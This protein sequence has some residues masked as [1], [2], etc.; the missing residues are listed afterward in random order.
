[1]HASEREPRRVL[2]AAAD[3]AWAGAQAQMLELAA[4]LDPAEFAPVLLTTGT[5]ELVERARAAG[6]PTHL[7]PFGIVRRQFPFVDYYA[8]GPLR[9]HALLSRERIALVH[10]HDPNSIVSLARAAGRRRVPIV[11]HIHDLDQRWVTKRTVAALHTARSAFATTSD[12]AA[13]YAIGCGAD[14]ERVRRIYNGVHLAAF[15]AGTRPRVRAGLH[16]RDDEVAV[17]LLGRMVERKGQADLVRAVADARVAALP[18]RVF[19]IGGTATRDAAY[20]Q[21]LRALATE[22]GVASRVTFLGEREDATLLLGGMDLSVVP[23]RREA[24]GRVVVEGMHAGTPVVAYDDGA[25]PEIVRD[26][27]D[28]FVVPTGDI[29]ALAGAIARLASDVALRT[30]MSE[31][32]RARAREFSHQRFVERTTALYRELLNGTSS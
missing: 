31:S 20:E 27:R 5:G 18:V 1:M 32:A 7:L 22:L 3:S 26:G 30:R 19:L 6:V 11:S 13:R 4:G 25:L 24:F 16:L 23:S 9:L 14:P 8:L 17:A 29:A 15:P 28:G 2:F 10:T 12:A 21:G